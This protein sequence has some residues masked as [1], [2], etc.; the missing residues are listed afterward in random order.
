M[1]KMLIKKNLTTSI[2]CDDGWVDRKQIICKVPETSDTIT[3][4]I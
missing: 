3:H 2:N 1:F 4:I